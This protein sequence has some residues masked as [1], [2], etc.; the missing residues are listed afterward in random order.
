[1]SDPIYLDMLTRGLLWACDALTEE[2][3]PKAAYRVGGASSGG[4]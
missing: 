3:K 1:M 2:G 4:E